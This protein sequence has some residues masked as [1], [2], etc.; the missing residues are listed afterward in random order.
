MD[1]LRDSL[2]KFKKGVKHRLGRSKGKGDKPGA[3]G[4]E[5]SVGSSSPFPQT[6]SRDSTGVG[7]EQGDGPDTEN[8]NAGASAVNKPN[9]GSTAS[10]SAKLVLRGVRDSADAFG[11]L[12]S[13]AGGLCFILENYEVQYLPSRTISKTYRPQRTKANK[14]AIESLAPQVEELHDLL[15]KPVKEGDVKERERRARLE[16]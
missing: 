1:D 15:C 12:K 8:E 11:P 13:V 10:S 16:R 3:S 4:R 6:E 5:E 7:R 2:S 9:W 14:Q